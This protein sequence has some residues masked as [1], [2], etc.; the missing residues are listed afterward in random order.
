ML[1]GQNWSLTTLNSKGI[2]PRNE[3]TPP[4]I[5]AQY[6]P[7]FVWKRQPQIRVTK[8][9]DKKLWLSLSVE[10]PQVTYTGCTT[11]VNGTTVASNT[12]VGNLVTCDLGGNNN[13]NGT[14]VTNFSLNHVPDVV[15]KAAYEARIADRDVHF[16]GFGLY[17]DLYDRVAYTA[18]AT[19]VSASNQNTTGYGVGG[20]LIVP[21]LPRRLDFQASGMYGRGIGS[22]G[23]AQFTDATFNSNGSAAPIREGMLLA[24][25][26]AHVTPSIDVYAFGGVEQVQPD[27]YTSNAAGTTFAGYGAPNANNSGC[28]NEIVAATCAGNAKRVWQITGGMWDKLYKGTFGEVRAGLQYSY[29]EREL[30]QGNGG[31]AVAL[32]Y[33]PRQNDQS[34]LTSLRYYPF[35]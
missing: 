16:E 10:Q 6:V 1:A 23:T 32:P 17:R 11:G 27:Y 12:G 29:T 14:A 21:V 30:F 9:F 18:G 4:T 35:Q 5:D 13:L 19:Q 34:V 28:F 15:A 2:T 7:G 20:G 24:G 25:L 26:T 3:V 33:A 8:D 22:Y 31:G